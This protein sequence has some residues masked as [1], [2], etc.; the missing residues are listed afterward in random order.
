[1]TY[2]FLPPPLYIYTRVA[3]GSQHTSSTVATIVSAAQDEHGVAAN[4]T[5][6]A[7]GNAVVSTKQKKTPPPILVSFTTYQDAAEATFTMM[8]ASIS[9][10]A[11]AILLVVTPALAAGRTHTTIAKVGAGI[12]HPVL[13]PNAPLTPVE[14]GLMRVHAKQ[15]AS[16]HHHRHHHPRQHRHH[17]HQ[18]ARSGALQPV[19]L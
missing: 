2:C 8:N 16:H 10:V 3:L 17:L 1:M 15:C 6:I 7:E 11:I 9:A 19:M 14:K 12:I 4:A 13:K 18:A 5:A